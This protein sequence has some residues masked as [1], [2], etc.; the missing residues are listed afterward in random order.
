M[1]FVTKEERVVAENIERLKVLILAKEDL[2]LPTLRECRELEECRI[3][4]ADLLERRKPN[5]HVFRQQS[6]V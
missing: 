6:P 2:R 1:H 5:P 3:I 4:Y